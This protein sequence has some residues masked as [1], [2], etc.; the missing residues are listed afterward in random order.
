[1]GKLEKVYSYVVVNDNTPI[2]K[3][4]L[5]D[6][7][8]VIMKE[9]TKNIG[10]QLDNESVVNKEIM[11]L[12]AN[13]YDFLKKATDPI[14]KGEHSAVLV[15]VP[16]LYTPVWKDVINEDLFTRH[17]NV[18]VFKPDMDYDLPFDYKILFQVVK[19]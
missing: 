8:R 16:S 17:Y 7:L 12:Q 14:R 1:M 13:L 2:Q 3:L 4:P 19:D 5:L 15:K 11:T 10:A 6:L 9:L 18:T